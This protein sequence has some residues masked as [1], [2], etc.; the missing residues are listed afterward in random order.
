VTP[1]AATV[2]VKDTVKT[3]GDKDP[4]FTFEADGLVTATESLEGATITR[5]KGDTVGTYKINVAF[6]DG[7]NPNYKLTITPGTLTINPK[8]VTLTADNV[9]KKFGETDPELTYTV[10]SLVKLGETE[11]KL[12]GVKLT[13]EKGENAGTYDI[14]ATVDAKANPNYIV[15]VAKG[16][17]L[18]IIANNDQ[19]VVVVK[20]HSS[21]GVY[22]GKEQTV[23]GFDISTESKAY[24]LKFVEFTGDSVVS[25]IDAGTYEMGLSESNFKNTSVNYP[26]VVFEVTDGS[27]E[28][29]PKSLVVSA[30]ADSITYGE[31]LPTEFK[32]T[33]DS[34][35]NGDALDNIHVSIEKTGLLD[36]GEY[37]LDFDKKRT[38]DY[39]LCC[40]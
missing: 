14:T 15:T 12:A 1:K 19:I 9:S 4:T 26:N 22:S 7:S 16:G 40:K 32:W 34:L 21:T 13:R 8:A 2:T 36:A 33:V 18:T 11:D 17:S 35:L 20:G 24:D 6:E 10:D 29:T 28:I 31:E 5:A 23:K 39:E 3:Y 27:L 38:D 37:V 30:V 25:G